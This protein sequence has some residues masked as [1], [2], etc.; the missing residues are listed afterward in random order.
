MINGAGLEREEF[1]ALS[2]QWATGT[3]QVAT[4]NRVEHRPRRM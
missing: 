2:S 3:L 4:G 1:L